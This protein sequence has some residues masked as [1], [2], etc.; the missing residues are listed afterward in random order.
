MLCEVRIV[1]LTKEKNVRYLLMDEVR[2]RYSL[3]WHQSGLSIIVAIPA[4]VLAGAKIPE[5]I[6]EAMRED[7]GFKVATPSLRDNFGFEKSLMRFDRGEKVEFIAAL[8]KLGFYLD[9]PCKECGGEKEREGMACLYCNGKGLEYVVKHDDVNALSASLAILFLSLN[10][11]KGEIPG[12]LDRQF[13]EIT[14]TARRGC[15]G[16]CG[17]FG[18]LVVRWLRARQGHVFEME[19]A[20]RRAYDHMFEGNRSFGGQCE[21]KI[22]DRNGWLNVTI[23]GQGCGLVPNMT[24]FG[25]HPGYEF[26]DHN[27]DN[28]GQQLALLAG[29]AALHDLT[30]FSL[31]AA[32]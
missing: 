12:S 3:K 30:H 6:F 9:R 8:P 24:G 22:T 14:L 31:S 23:P 29:L 27:V 18:S 17:I 19:T 5:G 4:A 7:F 2:R 25:R 1:I 15:F 20:M 11:M 26:S 32:A 28:A 10:A 13:M 16:I 21:A